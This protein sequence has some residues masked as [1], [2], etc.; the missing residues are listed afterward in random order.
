MGVWC[1]V[2]SDYVSVGVESKP[3]EFKWRMDPKHMIMLGFRPGSLRIAGLAHR[4]ACAARTRG[5]KGLEMPSCRIVSLVPHQLLND[6]CLK[7]SV[8]NNTFAVRRARG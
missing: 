2:I 4:N 1:R 6:H 7:C 3:A 5:L 8:V